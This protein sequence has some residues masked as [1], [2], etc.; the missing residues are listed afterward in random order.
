MEFAWCGP[1][2][3][4]VS[5]NWEKYLNGSFTISVSGIDLRVC[6]INCQQLS[7]QF[8]SKIGKADR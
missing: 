4:F 8:L 2:L 7:F 5:N 6:V 1:N 3:S